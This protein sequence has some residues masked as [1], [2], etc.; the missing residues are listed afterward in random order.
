[1][2]RWEKETQCTT[3]IEFY[4]L[5]MLAAVVNQLLCHVDD[6]PVDELARALLRFKRPTLRHRIVTIP[7]I[8]NFHFALNVSSSRVQSRMS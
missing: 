6:K 3:V 2:N 4:R 1:M 8:G 5:S 7:I